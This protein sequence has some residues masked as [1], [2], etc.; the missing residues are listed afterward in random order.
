MNYK[1]S[2][3]SVLNIFCTVFNSEFNY[4]KFRQMFDNKF[5]VKCNWKFGG[6]L[7]IYITFYKHLLNTINRINAQQ[8]YLLIELLLNL[9]AAFCVEKTRFLSNFFSNS[10]F[11]MRVYK[12][13]IEARNES[14]S[15]YTFLRISPP[16]INI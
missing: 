12:G 10:E 5:C 11:R 4:T 15:L 2:W 7:K 13:K 16:K 9:L 8:N 6:F 1:V 14:I 3:T